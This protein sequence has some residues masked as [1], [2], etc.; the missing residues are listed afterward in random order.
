MAYNPNN[1]PNLRND[2]LAAI[3]VYIVSPPVGT[4]AGLGSA[5]T[6]PG[7]RSMVN[8]STLPALGNVGAAVVG[9]GTNTVP[10]Y[11]DGTTWRIGPAI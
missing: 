11:S 8:D 5:S 2:A 4:V 7:V 9:G 6:Q 1:P 3:P 10:V